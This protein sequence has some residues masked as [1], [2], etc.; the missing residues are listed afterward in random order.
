MLGRPIR[1]RRRRGASEWDTGVP[2]AHVTTE[3]PFY[4]ARERFVRKRSHLITPSRQHPH[5]LEHADP[6]DERLRTQVLTQRAVCTR[7]AVT[8]R[9]GLGNFALRVIGTPVLLGP[10]RSQHGKRDPG[11]VEELEDPLNP[12]SSARGAAKEPRLAGS[13]RAGVLRLWRI[14][15]FLLLAET[16]VASKSL[17]G[18]RW[19][20]RSRCGTSFLD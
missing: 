3:R 18:V 2:A 6:R 15:T 11:E 12:A 17:T 13:S 5:R 16:R 1:P 10:G 20:A 7:L 14:G 9:T 4:D 8:S 19:F